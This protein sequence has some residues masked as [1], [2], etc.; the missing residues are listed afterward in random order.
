[1]MPYSTMRII[2]EHV[3]DVIPLLEMSAGQ[4]GALFN[5]KEP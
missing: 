5:P 3:T 4:Y 1:M 2:M